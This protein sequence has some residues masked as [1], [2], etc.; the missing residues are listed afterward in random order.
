LILCRLS[1]DGYVEESRTKLL[2]GRV[3]GH[4]AFAGRRMIAK[5][6]GGEAWRT[7]APHE[8]VCVDLAQE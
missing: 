4:P 2:S 8:V 3:W 1:P 7:G 5:T 6:D